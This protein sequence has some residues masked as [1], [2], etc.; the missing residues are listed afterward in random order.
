MKLSPATPAVGARLR[1][2]VALAASTLLAVAPALQAGPPAPQGGTGTIKGKLI[3]DGGPIPAPKVAVK[4][5][6]PKVKDEIC[7][8]QEILNRDLTIDPATKGVANGF[9]YLVKPDRETS[10]SSRPPPRPWSRST[11]RSSSTRST[12]NTSPTPRWSIRARSCSSSRATRSGTTSTSRPFANGPINPML[13]PNGKMEFPAKKGQGL[14]E[15]RR[16][17]EVVC[18]IHPWMKGYFFVLDHPFATVTKPDGTFE[19]TGV[20][21]GSQ[22]LV[23]WQSLNGYVTPGLNKGMAVTVKAGET[24]DVGDVKI[25]K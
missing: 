18:D 22:Q 8:A 19:I 16:P 15:E 20:P 13:A 24:T 5:G 25:S 9:A 4:K 23:I 21:A 17:T 11:P 2:L 10:R 3:W 7:K 1:P 14:K 6:D 12:A